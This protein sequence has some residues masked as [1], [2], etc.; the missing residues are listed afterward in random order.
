MTLTQI[1]VPK[2][3]ENLGR[4]I[5]RLWFKESGGWGVNF[6]GRRVSAS[7]AVER[8]PVGSES[9]LLSWRQAWEVCLVDIIMLSSLVPV[10]CECSPAQIRSLDI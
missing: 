7:E 2:E 1:I 6:M 8:G 10:Y 3:R 4:L 5:L 9:P